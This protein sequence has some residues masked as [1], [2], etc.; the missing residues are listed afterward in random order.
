VIVLLAGLLL[1]GLIS[2]AG[3]LPNTADLKSGINH[4]LARA[5]ATA[6]RFSPAPPT[7]PEEFTDVQDVRP[8]AQSQPDR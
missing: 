1:A 5:A 8:V 2:A 4:V 7:R 3:A 6:P